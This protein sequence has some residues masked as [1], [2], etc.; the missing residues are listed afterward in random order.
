MKKAYLSG[1][2]LENTAFLNAYEAGIFWRGSLD[3]NTLK[4]AFSWRHLNEALSTNR[5]TND[6][7][8]LSLKDS[9]AAPKKQV[10][11]P[12]KDS[13][14]RP[15]D[16]LLVSELRRQL[17]EQLQAEIANEREKLRPEVNDREQQQEGLVTSLKSRSPTF[18]PSK[19]SDAV[20]EEQN[21]RHLS[22]S[23]GLE[24]ETKQRHTLA[25]QL[26]DLR[27]SG[28]FLCSLS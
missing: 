25:Q 9:Y 19:G 5:I 27:D 4:K 11:R 7:F 10:F 15:T 14:G 16:Y 2:I 18:T 17:A 1:A 28:V 23:S 13:F 26:R 22:V 3:K 6:R 20:I 21:K 8:R 24:H 12:T